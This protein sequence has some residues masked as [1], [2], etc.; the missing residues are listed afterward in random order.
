[1]SLQEFHEL[2]DIEL[3]QSDMHNAV[4]MFDF[5]YQG[6][7]CYKATHPEGFALF[8]VKTEDVILNVIDPAD[9]FDIIS[10]DVMTY[11]IYD[12]QGIFIRDINT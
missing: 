11:E 9:I 7:L 4:F 12:D 8:K 2:L 1:M 3:S 5:A 10:F 6:L